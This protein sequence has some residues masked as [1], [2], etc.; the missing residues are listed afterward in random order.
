[1]GLGSWPRICTDIGTKPI[2]LALFRIPRI[3]LP[4]RPARGQVK[5]QVIMS[6]LPWPSSHGFKKTPRLEWALAQTLRS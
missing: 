6:V 5:N 1:M 4:V 2:P 3:N